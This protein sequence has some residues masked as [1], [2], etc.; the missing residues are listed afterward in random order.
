MDRNRWI[1]AAVGLTAVVLL[2]ALE[3]IPQKRVTLAEVVLETLELALMLAAAVALA[4]LFER[5]QRQ[6]EEKV[7]L[8]RDLQTARAEGAG[9]RRQVQSHLDGLGAAIEGQFQSWGLTDAEREVGLLMLKGFSHKEIAALRGT[10]ETTARQQAT[11]AYQKAG[12][13]GRAA[14]CAYFLEDLLVPGAVETGSARVE[15]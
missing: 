11:S 8:I 10:T 3:F 5:M 6:H 2:L 14:F 9:L 4:L 13:G 7:A 15:H 1:Y 12:L